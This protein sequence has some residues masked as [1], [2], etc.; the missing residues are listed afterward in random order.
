MAGI[1]CIIILKLSEPFKQC[2][3]D[4]LVES[5]SKVFLCGNTTD[6]NSSST[7]PS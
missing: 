2:R 4:F 6:G 7:L 5:Y 3:V 1:N